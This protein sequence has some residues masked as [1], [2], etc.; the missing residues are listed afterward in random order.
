MVSLNSVGLFAPARTAKEMVDR[1][2]RA[3]GNAMSAP[4]W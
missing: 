3:T 1:I 2:D 4:K